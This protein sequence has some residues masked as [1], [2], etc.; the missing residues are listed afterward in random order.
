[1]RH[2]LTAN[3]GVRKV[4]EERA[5]RFPCQHTLMALRK[6]SE[7]RAVRFPCQHTLMALSWLDQT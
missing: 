4:S 2:Q 6:V 5:V 1:M 3:N 7:E